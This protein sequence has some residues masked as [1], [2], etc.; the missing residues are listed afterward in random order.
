[1]FAAF[2]SVAAPPAIASAQG[3]AAP[4]PQSRCGA[5][6]RETELFAPVVLGRQVLGEVAAYICDGRP[7]EADWP[8][9][10]R[11]LTP[12]LDDQAAERLGALEAGARADPAIA[13][14]LGVSIRFD[15]SELAF[16]VSLSPQLGRAAE[17]SFVTE[18]SSFEPGLP[19]ARFSSYLNIAGSVSRASSAGVQAPSFLLS[20]AT[21]LS[22][23]AIE[24]EAELEEQL[25]PEGRT[26]YNV[27]RNFARAVIDEPS[28][29]R[30]WFL[31]E[32]DSEAVGLQLATGLRGAGVFRSTRE[33]GGGGLARASLGRRLFLT[34]DSTVSL[35]RNGALFRE[36]RLGPGAYDLTD[37][38][39]LT[40]TTDAR[41]EIRDDLGRTEVL[42]FNNFYKPSDLN[43]GDFEYFVGVGQRR[44]LGGT[45]PTPDQAV[46]GSAFVRKALRGGPV[47]SL[48]AQG[49]ANFQGGNAI[50]EVVAPLNGFLRLEGSGVRSEVGVGYAVAADYSF[51][52]D[53]PRQDAFFI[54]VQAESQDFVSIGDPAA[55]NT[56]AL[57]AS[58]Q[59]STNLTER[60]QLRATAATARERGLGT[61][62]FR[63][64]LDGVFR[65]R[66]NLSGAVGVSYIDA[67]TPDRG[68]NFS[69]SLIWRPGLR[70]RAEARYDSFQNQVI[71]SFERANP[72]HV[73]GLGA[74]AV[75]ARQDGN[76]GITG[77]V[78]YVANRAF[79]ALAQGVSGEDLSDFGSQ[80]GT[81]LSA[82]TGLAYA[83]GAFG[84]GRP[85][86]NSFAVLKGH[87][88]L[89]G[90]PV[91]V[92]QLG[93]QR[94]YAA[95][96]GPLGGALV[97]GLSPYIDQSIAY[98][99]PAAPS[100]YDLGAGVY[101]VRPVNRSGYAFTVGTDAF[102]TAAGTLRGPDGAPVSLGA[103]RV[104]RL[105]R[106][107][108][109]LQF[110]TNSVG[111]FA[112]SGLAP[113]GRYRVELFR[114]NLVVEFEVPSDTDG[115]FDLSTLVAEPQP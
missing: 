75:V 55:L 42:E 114:S 40:G 90:A 108:D 46:T 31:G 98:D 83:Q 89:K 104:V 60:F 43:P 12:A 82:S 6:G 17:L 25:V 63:G 32:F 99:V 85:V 91:V 111:R 58:A 59:Y 64:G 84:W 28:S 54:G 3:P 71:G 61:N 37:I 97:G 30:R 88:T 15:Y 73:G 50:L 80:I 38:P 24:Y 22:A 35:F 33:F 77:S 101:R 86:S 13:E 102:V 4:A 20:G 49:D 105:D 19:P 78:N 11:L 76:A 65:L 106:P 16:F 7:T 66:S 44:A 47:V 52:L 41:V 53:N 8:A 2:A 39:L 93:D 81:T 100:G 110:F 29:R 95:R 87:P 51:F 5:V 57:T 107:M 109:E 79:V 115:L 23:V 70:D 96:S 26:I 62:T 68:L 9:M 18:D 67:D 103:G 45:V 92:G 74:S 94:R 48:G 34:Q 112:V 10:V 36:F 27:R 1:M 72:G 113:G 21:R 14:A 56:T 69:L